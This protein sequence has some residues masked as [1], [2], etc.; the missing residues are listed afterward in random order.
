MA[1]ARCLPLTL[2]GFHEPFVAVA[3]PCGYAGSRNVGLAVHGKSVFGTSFPAGRSGA[4]RA[5]MLLRR[6][7]PVAAGREAL[8]PAASSQGA[9]TFS[10][11]TF[12]ARGSIRL[13]HNRQPHITKPCSSWGAIAGFGRT[14]DG[15]CCR[16][17]PMRSRSVHGFTARNA[18]G[19]LRLPHA[20]DPTDRADW[21]LFHRHPV[22]VPAASMGPVAS[23]PM[24]APMQV[25][26]ARPSAQRIQC[27]DQGQLPP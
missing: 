18:G 12:L 9:G 21:Y 15:T 13:F 22:W 24:R 19:Q 25:T 3:S 23:F 7:I 8:V 1:A 10:A 14:R 26:L 11:F 20:L 6:F 16:Q 27:T 5:D 4:A 17:W 2:R